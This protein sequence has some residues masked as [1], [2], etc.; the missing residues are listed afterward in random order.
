MI[1]TPSLGLAKK[2]FSEFGT[3]GASIVESL[4]GNPNFMITEPTLPVVVA[5]QMQYNAAVTAATG[6][7]TQQRQFRKQQREVYHVMLTDLANDVASRSSGDLA[8]YLTSGF[9]YKRGRI[10]SGTPG[11]A[12]NYRLAYN[13]LSGQLVSRHNKVAGAVL[14][15]VFIG[16]TATPPAALLPTAFAVAGPAPGP[17]PGAEWWFAG[18]STSTTFIITGLMPKTEYFSRCVV[19]GSKGLVGPWSEIASK[20][21][22]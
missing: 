20:I 16:I 3:F 8:I 22:I 12:Q 17:A 9:N 1:I 4:T 7:N 6:G 15:A 19:I 14:Y 11:A 5:E 13:K 2:T 10:P 18:V 21:C